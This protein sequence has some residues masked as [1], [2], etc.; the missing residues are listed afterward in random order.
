M[1]T[2]YTFVVGGIAL[3]K[4]GNIQLVRKY[5]DFLITDYK[6]NFFAQRLPDT[7]GVETPTYIY[8]FFNQSGCFSLVEIAQRNEWDCY[9]AKQFMQQAHCLLSI[10]INQNDYIKRSIYTTRAY[11][12][13]TAMFIQSQIN[14]TNGFWGIQVL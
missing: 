2:R 1:E 13:H 14:I 5:F 7:I 10:R 6:M 9:T 3:Q 8:S 4:L 11:L 12:K